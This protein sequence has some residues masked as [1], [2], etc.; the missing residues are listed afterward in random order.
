GDDGAALPG[1]W[2]R[3]RSLNGADVQ[4]ADDTDSSGTA[5]LFGIRKGPVLLDVVH[6]IAG[7]CLGVPIDASTDETEFVLEARGSLEVK[8]MDGEVPIGGAAVRMETTGGVS[9]SD[10][11]RTDGSGGARF[12]SL[13]AGS[14][15]LAC[16][17]SDCW[18]AVLDRKLDAREH[19]LVA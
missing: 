7:T 10:A 17:R 3:I 1:A 2:V 6:G 13:G 18:P 15:R 16:Q 11:R 19:A 8:V 5:E 9:L 14:Y 4:A 12:E